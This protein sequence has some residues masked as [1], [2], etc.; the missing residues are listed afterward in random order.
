[1]SERSITTFPW[2]HTCQTDIAKT[3]MDFSPI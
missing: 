2:Q 1:M 3:K